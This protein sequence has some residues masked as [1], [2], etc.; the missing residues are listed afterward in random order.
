MI[1]NKFH[2]FVA[3]NQPD[4]C[5][6]LLRFVLSN[7]NLSTGI[8]EIDIKNTISLFPNPTTNQINVKADIK[9][10]GTAYIV[11][12]NLGRAVFSGIINNENTLIEMG[13]LPGGIYTLSIGDNMKQIFKIIKQ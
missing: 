1:K 2:I 6:F 8:S 5:T 4:N 13:N 10:I 11:Y 12:D 9:L 7:I 3:I